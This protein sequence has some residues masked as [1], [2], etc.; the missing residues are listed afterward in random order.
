MPD[1]DGTPEDRQAL[2]ELMMKL[3]GAFRSLDSSA[4]EELYS[5]DAD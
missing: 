3:A 1:L 2:G 4:V 5:E